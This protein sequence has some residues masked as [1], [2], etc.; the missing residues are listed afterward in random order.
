M[1]QGIGSGRFSE[2]VMFP[3]SPR[4]AC[5]LFEHP[6]RM[7]IMPSNVPFPA[8]TA[9]DRIVPMRLRSEVEVVPAGGRRWNV[10]DPVVLQFYQFDEAEY[11]V[12]RLWDGNHSL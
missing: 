3:T 5:P 7:V 2:F 4:R 9:L 12:L 6:T 1:E 11:L 10:C 8:A